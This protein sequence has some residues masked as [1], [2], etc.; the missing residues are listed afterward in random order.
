MENNCF[1]LITDSFY[2]IYNG[3]INMC[4]CCSYPFDSVLNAM[5]IPIHMIPTEGIVGKRYFPEINF[6][7]DIELKSEKILLNL[8]KANDYGVNIQP[9]SG[10]QAN[11]IIYNAILSE[12]D[13]V[14]SLS[15]KNGGHIS[16]TKLAGKPN[17]VVH[18]LLNDNLDID[19][20]T[21]EKLIIDN[22]PKLLIVG[23]SSYSK[24]IDFESI[25]TIAH[26]HNCY[27]LADIC[28]YVLFILGGT[29][30]SCVPYVDFITFTMDK[31]LCGPQGG[32]II[33]RKE[34]K[35]KI[36]YSVF[37]TS[38]GGPLQSILF[39]KYICCCE[40]I[41]LDIQFY[42]KQV[43]KNTQLLVDTFKKRKIP[44]VY[45]RHD[46]HI[47]LINTSLLGINGKKA[48]QLLFKGKILSNKNQIPFD[49]NSLDAPSGIRIGSTCITNLNFDAEDVIKLANYISDIL[50][51]IK[52][53]TNMIEFLVQKYMN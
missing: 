34:F 42:A 16:H 51:N 50:L 35:S 9:H 31:L 21:L 46:N 49:N 29:M 36:N 7:D 11:Q 40:L 45:D 30:N 5:S 13:I 52:V 6:I 27:V 53:N 38:Q 10:T 39:A 15:P 18:Y 8:F 20:I 4:A 44:L 1:N 25:S 28:H 43:L 22:K 37:P 24:S 33:Y 41:K 19:L 26:R 12:D 2:K 17:K 32:I 48:E 14:L 47:I 3:Y 23:T